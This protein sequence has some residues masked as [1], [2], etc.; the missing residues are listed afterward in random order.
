MGNFFYFIIYFLKTRSC[1]EL[2]LPLSALK[3]LSLEDHSA[4]QHVL[5]V[6]HT[7]RLPVVV[8]LCNRTQFSLMADKFNISIIPFI[9]P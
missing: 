7:F 4:C 5:L 9:V 8:Y 2:R 1:V 6:Y 3:R